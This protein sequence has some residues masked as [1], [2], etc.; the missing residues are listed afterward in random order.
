MKKVSKELDL[1]LGI[2]GLKI[3]FFILLFFVICLLINLLFMGLTL[4]Q[5]IFI[6]LRVPT[7]NDYPI[8]FAGFILFIVIP[9]VLGIKLKK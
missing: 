7:Q 3:S 2:K 1:S 5:I 9:F 8:L 4:L 6:T